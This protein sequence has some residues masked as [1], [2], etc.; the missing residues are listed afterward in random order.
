MSHITFT[1][2]I[3]FDSALIMP[4]PEDLTQT[5]KILTKLQGEEINR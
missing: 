3:L 4:K 2:Q 5:F 1:R